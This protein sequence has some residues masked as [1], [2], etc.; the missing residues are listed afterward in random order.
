MA[1]VMVGDRFG[2]RLCGLDILRPHAD[3]VCL[4]A[5]DWVPYAILSN[6]FSGG[7]ATDQRIRGVTRV[8]TVEPDGGGLS[9]FLDLKMGLTGG[10]EH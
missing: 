10:T 9:L 8:L 4:S 5:E 2:A 7:S 1:V 3:A 6:R